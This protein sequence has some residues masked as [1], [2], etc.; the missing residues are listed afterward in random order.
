MRNGRAFTPPPDP[1][2][3]FLIR[4]QGME[5]HKI[6]VECR[7]QHDRVFTCRREGIG[8]HFPI[9]PM[10]QDIAADQATQWHEGYAFFGGLQHGVH[11]GAG[12]INHLDRTGTQCRR[13]ARREA[14][15]TKRYRAGLHAG[16]TARP[17]QDIGR[18][19]GNRYADQIEIA[20]P[21]PDQRLGQRDGGQGIIRRQGEA[22]PIGHLGGERFK[23]LQ[24]H[25]V[26]LWSYATGRRLPGLGAGLGARL[27]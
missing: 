12:G 25:G 19:A 5:K 11:G 13:K 15:L 6:R 26:L 7:Q 27:R 17:N 2:I 8:H 18:K 24:I 4:H 23:A 16:D 1:D 10:R 9:R 20:H 21:A 14:G 22:R 3:A